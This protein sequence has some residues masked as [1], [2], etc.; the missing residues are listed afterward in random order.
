[1]V[2]KIIFSACVTFSTFVGVQAQKISSATI[3]DVAAR[4][5]GPA[6]MGGRIT[7]IEGVNSKP[8]VVYVG[9]AG[10]GVW[11]TD[12]AGV[13]FKS[14]FD[15][16]CQ[17]IGD[18]AIDQKHPDTLWVSTRKSNMRN[19]VSIGNG[20]FMSKDGG[21][22]WQQMGLQKTEHISKV[23]IHPG[24]SNVLY[25]AAPGPLWSDG[26]DRGIYKTTDGGKTWEKIYYINERTGCADLIMDP[27]DPET[28]IAYRGNSGENLLPFHPADPQAGSLKVSMEVKRGDPSAKDFRKETLAEWQ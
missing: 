9:A 21:E 5:I 15:K 11:K 4:S 16:Y 18:I 20:I 25:V 17:S 23:I 24:N 3:G 2:K 10:G 19:T 8:K 1:M 13:S 27:R 14:I 26:P 22:N 28:L 7:C 6:V 12:D